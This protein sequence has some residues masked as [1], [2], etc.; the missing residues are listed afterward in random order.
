M[1]QFLFLKVEFR[2]I[3]A[4][5]AKAEARAHADAR[6]TEIDKLKTAHRAHLEKLDA[7]FAALQQSA[8]RGELTG[9]DKHLL[10]ATA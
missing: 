1:S 10:E 6:A 3:F 7:L 4:A 8:F 9:A 2:E 5:A